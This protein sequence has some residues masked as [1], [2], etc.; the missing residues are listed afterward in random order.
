MQKENLRSL[1]PQE[2]ELA[3][4]EFTKRNFCDPRYVK[5]NVK[6]KVYH[7]SGENLP[8]VFVLRHKDDGPATNSLMIHPL[9]PS[10]LLQFPLAENGRRFKNSNVSPF[11]VL[12]G[13]SANYYRV[14]FNSPQELG[15]ILDNL[16]QIGTDQYE[17]ID[18][19]DL[20][21]NHSSSGSK[22][23]TSTFLSDVPEDPL[24][25]I[26]TETVTE[27]GKKGVFTYKYERDPSL[28]KLA[29]QAFGSKC[30]VCGADFEE[31]YGKIGKG[32]IEFHHIV[33]V[34]EGVRE[35]NYK[36]LVPLCS[37]CH[38]M[39]HRL[40]RDIPSTEYDQA[41]RILKERL[42]K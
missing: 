32:F 8:H 23:S 24:S 15:A 41:V 3:I 26:E 35:N 20:P 28:R 22:I 9:T 16:I 38:R 30:S 7:F 13:K 10:H 40:Y 29:L 18:S 17:K 25:D 6:K 4:N 37:N 12:S 31:L 34:S 36:N 19:L 39:I 5:G 33:P 21:A 14:I 2:F 1:S 11:P 42:T 27:G